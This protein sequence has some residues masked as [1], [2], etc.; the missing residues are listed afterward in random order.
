MADVVVDPSPGSTTGPAAQMPPGLCRIER[1]KRASRPG[2][3]SPANTLHIG[4]SQ[5]MLLHMK[6]T[7]V[8]LPDELMARAKQKAAAQGRTLTSLIEDG[9]RMAVTGPSK[10]AKRRGVVLPRVS[11]ATGGLLPGVDLMRFSD[12]QAMEDE[13]Y[14]E[15]MKHFK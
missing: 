14:I 10:P 1:A 7:T 15:R 2:V 3:R 11:E 6:R 4:I 12:Y 5:H 8:I 13:E 9:V